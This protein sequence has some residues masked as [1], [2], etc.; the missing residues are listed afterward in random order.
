MENKPYYSLI[1]V[2][3]VLVIR[4][5]YCISQLSSGIR[6]ESFLPPHI[7]I[8]MRIVT[9]VFPWTLLSIHKVL[10][11]CLYLHSSKVKPSQYGLL[12]GFCGEVRGPQLLR[13]ACLLKPEPEP[14]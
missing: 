4:G 8:L 7:H 13:L 14:W 11:W 3:A 12:L 5:F 10:H 2:Q 9:H 1:H 6:I